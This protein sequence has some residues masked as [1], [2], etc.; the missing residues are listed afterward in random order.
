MQTEEWGPPMHPYP[1]DQ[2][3]EM[4]VKGDLCFKPEIAFQLILSE[5]KAFLHQPK[6]ASFSLWGKWCKGMLETTFHTSGLYEPL[7]H[8]NSF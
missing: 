5:R 2:A 3:L 7:V 4:R 6:V 8:W 1:E